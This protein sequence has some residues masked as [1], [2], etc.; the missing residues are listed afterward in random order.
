MRGE[1]GGKCLDSPGM[2]AGVSLYPEI[3]VNLPEHSAKC[4]SVSAGDVLCA[5]RD[6]EAAPDFT[7]EGTTRVRDPMTQLPAPCA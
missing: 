6:L 5:G 3:F 2:L 1:S 4:D 7:A